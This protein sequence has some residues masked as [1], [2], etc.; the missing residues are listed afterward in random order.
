MMNKHIVAPLLQ[1][2]KINFFV[3]KSA[4]THSMACQNNSINQYQVDFQ[5]STGERIRWGAIE[6]KASQKDGFP[7]DAEKIVVLSWATTC[8]LSFI[9]TDCF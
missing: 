8:Q 5:K 1:Y 4:G 3:P 6:D 7:S 9:D 2:N